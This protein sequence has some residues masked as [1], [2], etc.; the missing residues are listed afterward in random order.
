MKF[1]ERL[2]AVALV[3][4]DPAFRNLVD[5]HGI[6]IVQLLAPAPDGSDQICRLQQRQVLAHGLARHVEA[7]GKLAQGL[8]VAGME[9]VQQQPA[10]LIR[11]RLEHLVHSAGI[12]GNQKVACQDE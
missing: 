3:F 6:E 10:A 11:Q 8:A 1:R 4:A 2:Q 5:R 9:P 12:I 7:G